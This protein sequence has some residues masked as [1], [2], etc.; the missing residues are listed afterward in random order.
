MRHLLLLFL[1]F[2]AFCFGQ[3]KKITHSEIRWKAYKM[4]KS[5]SFAHNGTIDLRSGAVLI[6]NDELQA[7]SF[8]FDMNSIDAKDMQGNPKEKRYL[9]N[10][11]KSDDFFSVE[12]YPFATFKITS[13]Q[14]TQGLYNTKLMGLLTIKNK[15]KSISI[16][17]NVT[18]N[19]NDSYVIKSD[20][21]TINRHD[22]DIH[23]NLFKDMLISDG[24]DMSFNLTAQ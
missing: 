1:L 13:I 3:I 18:K 10:H 14:E 6:K 7:G 8:I 20:K 16:P 23:Y 22:F 11:L 17:V 21:F 24:I 12:Q 9:E 5:E 4:M 2:N 15:S 19:G